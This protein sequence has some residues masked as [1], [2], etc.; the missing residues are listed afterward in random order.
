MASVET[1]PVRASRT[2]T[3]PVLAVLLALGGVLGL[4]AL[5]FRTNLYPS[6][7]EPDSAAGQFELTLWRERRAQKNF[8]GNAVTGV[9][10]SRFAYYPRIANQLMA[11]TG[12][13]FRSAGVPGSNPQSWYYMLRDLDPTSSRYR[14]I[15]IGVDDYDDEDGAFEPDTDIRALH[16]AI[17]RLR[18]SDALDFARSFHGFALQFQ[19]FRGA[20]LKG[21]VLQSD[22]LAFLSHPEKRIA[23]VHLQ[24][25]GFEE[26]TY[27]YIESDHSLAGLQIDWKTMTATYPPGA[28]WLQ[29]ETVKNW[30]LHGPDPADYRGRLRAFRLTWLGRIIDRYR[31]SRTKIIFVRLPRGPIPRPAYLDARPTSSIRELTRRPN[32]LLCD[33]HAFEP[34][35]HPELFKDGLH[36]N[37]EGSTRFSH[38]LANEVK[39]LLTR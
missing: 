22:I 32:V 24:H 3:R 25:S 30:S 23:D 21:M 27:N 8:G 9:G 15:M 18:F 10:D 33:E 5:L 28:D 17:V 19:A 36:L 20:I 4:D 26:W 2:V 6:V 16:F 38:M 14:A 39:R 37:L 29:R 1:I 12:L 7:L 35:E 11:E 34:L 31:N 13:V